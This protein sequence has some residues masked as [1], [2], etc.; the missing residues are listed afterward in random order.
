MPRWFP[1]RRR[2]NLGR[3]V[4]PASLPPASVDDLVDEGVII[5]GAAVRLAV[6]NLMVVRSV[7][8][9]LDFD[10]ER[11]VRAVREELENLAHEKDADADRIARVHDDA[12]G[13]S[14]RPVHHSDYRAVDADTLERREDVSRALADRLRQLSG[15]DQ[16]AREVVVAARERAL[17]AIEASVA[18]HADRIPWH[19]DEE[20]HRERPE[21]LR[22][23]A[24]DLLLLQVTPPSTPEA[25]DE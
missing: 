5:A 21:R 19:R 20:Y 11:Y 4:P 6:T 13:R 23:L 14:G 18:A 8:D 22:A 7:R 25:G 2:L 15:D 1:R 24:E 3:F 12:A 10:E 9:R 16:W 17:E